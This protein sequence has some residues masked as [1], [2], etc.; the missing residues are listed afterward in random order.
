M[1]A[2]DIKRD[3]KSY[4]NKIKGEIPDALK[5][6]PLQRRALIDR[7]VAL[8]PLSDAERKDLGA[9]S[10]LSQYKSVIGTA[11]SRMEQ[12]GDIEIGAAG[13]IV[14][15]KKPQTIV[16]EAEIS[17][18]II[19][20]VKEGAVTYKELAERAITYFGAERTATVDDDVTVEVMVKRLLPD[21][22]RR[23][24]ISHSYGKYTLSPDSIVIKKPRSLFEEFMILLNSKGGEFFENYSA[25]LLDK[26]YRSLGMT[27]GYCNVIGGSDDGG[28]DVILTVSDQLGFKDKILV[29]CKQKSGTNVTL[30][31]LKEFVGAFYVDKGTRGIYMTTARFHKEASLLFND[32]PDIIPIDG[33]KLFDIAKKCEC[34]VKA[35]NGGYEIDREFFSA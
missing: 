8:S 23:G 33:A 29:Q 31:E 10:A 35:V 7:L 25:M 20:Q 21:L 13:E 16:R 30:K 27:V 1:T 5:D 6:G 32:L 3:Y 12:Y 28:I 14:L 15:K 19:E 11:I 9:Q 4:L 34:G 26:Y 24:K 2:A 17:R 18:F 22:V